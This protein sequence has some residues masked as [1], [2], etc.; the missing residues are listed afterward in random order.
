M[1]TGSRYGVSRGLVRGGGRAIP[2]RRRRPGI[3]TFIDDEGGYTTIAL[4]VA[5]LVSVTLVFGTAAAAWS[6]A[7]AADVQQVADAAALAGENAV[8][9]F[10]TVAQVSDACVLSMG[11]AGV[12]TLGAGLV[13]AAIPPAAAESEEVI[14]TGRT[15]LEDRRSFATSAAE[16]LQRLEAALPAIVVSAQSDTRKQTVDSLV[17]PL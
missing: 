9:G 5:M 17:T 8:A 2:R 13:L 7:R 10:T 6:Q 15:L 12:V 16:G 3:G 11:I 1:G 14:Q 4:V